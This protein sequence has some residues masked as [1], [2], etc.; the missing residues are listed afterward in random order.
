MSF[1][2]GVAKL[3]PEA[4]LRVAIKTSDTGL[5]R[6]VLAAHPG[7]LNSAD[8]QGRTPLHLAAEWQDLA[9]VAA[10][11]DLGADVAA[12]DHGGYTP[13]ETALWCG[14]YRNGAYTEVCQ[15]IV[16]CLV[17]RPFS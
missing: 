7:L 4:Q 17:N 3:P 8:E 16:A 2:E 15:K 11:V 12:R 1:Y 14:E 5:L 6:R 9:I 10:L 13:H